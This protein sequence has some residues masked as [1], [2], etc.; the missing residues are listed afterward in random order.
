MKYIIKQND[1]IENIQAVKN[2]VGSAQIIGVLKGNGYGF[3]RDYMAKLL[4]E[5]GIEY[6]IRFF[7]KYSRNS[8]GVPV[9]YIFH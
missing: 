8:K 5:N 2:E 3:G 6:M 9:S 4:S 7:G 1:I